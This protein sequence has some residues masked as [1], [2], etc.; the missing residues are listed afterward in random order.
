MALFGDLLAVCVNDEYRQ[1]KRVL[2]EGVLLVL[3]GGASSFLT[4][5]ALAALG[6]LL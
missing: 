1:E 3:L 6:I 4:A 2:A 5:Y